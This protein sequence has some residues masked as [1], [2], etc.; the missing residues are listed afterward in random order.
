MQVSK[1][2]VLS[3]LR[4]NKRLIEMYQLDLLEKP[5]D[6]YIKSRIADYNYKIMNLETWV[7]LNA[8]EVQS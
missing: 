8:S 2:G 3:R 7:A 4:Q 5:N 1:E 6:A